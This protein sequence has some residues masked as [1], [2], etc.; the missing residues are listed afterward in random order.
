M[1]S[2]IDINKKAWNIKTDIH[3]ESEFYDN[4]SFLE[5]RN[6]LNQIELDILGDIS[7]LSI[8]HLQC[9]FGQDS[10]S[11]ARMGANV[12]GIDLSDN[13]IVK[14][15][16]LAE[17][18]NVNVDFIACDIY[19]LPQFLDKQYDIVFTT[20]G[21]IG[22]LPDLEKWAAI[23]SRF[24]KENGRFVFVEFHPY[25]WM[26]DDNFKDIVYPYFNVK[27]IIETNTGS[28]ADRSAVMSYDTISWNHSTSEV[29]NS[30]IKNDIEIKSFNEYDYSPYPCFN[31]LIE[32]DNCKYQIEHLQGMIPMVFSIEGI[33]K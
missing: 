25:V 1:D 26:F 18:V 2:Y 11:L 27:S 5:G 12:T 13:A 6:S 17:Q 31:N 10:I 28:Y 19:D 32:I 14:A 7:G 22:W 16:A 33:K 8:L 29:L 9:H 3:I 24:L 15:K 30:L 23:V 21:T 20:Y 4:I